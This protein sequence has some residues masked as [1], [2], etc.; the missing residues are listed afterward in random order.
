V[1]YA[2]DEFVADD[3]EDA[4]GEADADGDAVRGLRNVAYI[5]ARCETSRRRALEI[6]ICVDSFD[7]HFSVAIFTL[8]KCI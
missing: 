3:A 7:F 4:T 1:Y 6:A 8:V 5:L 2:R